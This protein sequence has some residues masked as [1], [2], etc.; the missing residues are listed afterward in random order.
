MPMIDGATK[1]G[2]SITSDWT[3]LVKLI[4][5]VRIREVR[6][7][8][9]SNG[10]LTEVYRTDWAVDDGIVQ[11]VF[12]VTIEPGGLSAWH[13]HQHATDRLFVSAGILKIVLY[14][15]RE[16]SPS[17]GCV[18]E[19]RFGIQRPALVVIPPGVWHG[20][21]NTGDAPALL[22]NLVDRAY[23]YENPDHWR[24][25]SDTPKI[26]YRFATSRPSDAL[27]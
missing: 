7:V 12:Q 16:D 21:Q 17:H 10:V 1:D 24:L 20:V 14:D 13:A 15:A 2:Q 25:P 4:D 6:N 23:Q 8:L 11:Q 27:R 22:L 3:P 9:K 26:P 19:L 18:N 5:G